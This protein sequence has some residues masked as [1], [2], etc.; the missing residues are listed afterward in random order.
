MLNASL[1][2][3]AAA[4]AQ[5]KISSVEL[6]RLFLGRVAKLNGS[7]NAFITVDAEKSVAQARAADERIAKGL[8]QPLT[9]IP[10]AHKDIFVTRGWLTTCGS[11]ILSNFVGPYDAHV[12][13]R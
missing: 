7:L 6:T 5:K 3:L 12:I 2:E 4:L 8:T 1:K 9:G 11:K 13:E 10:V